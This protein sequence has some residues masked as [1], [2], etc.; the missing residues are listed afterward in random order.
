VVGD[1]TAKK[2]VQRAEKRAAKKRREAVA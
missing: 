1:D 2:I